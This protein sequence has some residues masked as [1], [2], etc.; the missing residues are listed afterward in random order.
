MKNL[1]DYEH[2]T[3]AL[4]NEESHRQTIESIQEAL[5][6]LM[7]KKPLSDISIKELCEKAG[8]SRGAF[9]RNYKTK[10]EVLQHIMLNCLNEVYPRM[11]PYRL[12]IYDNRF[13]LEFFKYALEHKH[14]YTLIIQ[15]ET[16]ILT[17]DFS[18]QIAHQIFHFDENNPNYLLSYM[19]GAI[20]K[21]FFDWI[22]HGM[23]ESPEEMADF[24]CRTTR[25]D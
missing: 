19:I 3:Y 20:A 18:E 5:I 13:W 8:V 15:N 25:G 6:L 9:Y 24:L 11:Y 2:P 21:V 16:S 7:G 23:I 22:K 17:S 14:L 1:L 4:S 10:D 12:D